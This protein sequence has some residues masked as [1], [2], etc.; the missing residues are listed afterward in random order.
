M[1][2]VSRSYRSVRHLGLVLAACTFPLMGC[3]STPR[4]EAPPDAAAALAPDVDPVRA[5]LP[6]SQVPPTLDAPR[7]PADL[8]ALSARAEEQIGK[9][10]PLMEELRYT[11]AALELERALRYD[12]THPEIHRTLALLHWQ[13]G[14]IERARS[15]AQR[16]VDINS[17]AA[18]AHYILG[19]YAALQE[20]MP[21]ALTE[22]RLALMCSDV[23]AQ[24][25]IEVLCHYHLAGALSAEGYLEA[26]LGEY[27]AF[28]QRAAALPEGPLRAELATLLRTT[29]G[30][31]G[32]SK[33]RLLERL[34]RFAE[35]ADAYRPI[36]AASPGEIER[37]TRFA[38][39]LTQAAKY[40]AALDVARAIESDDE[41]AVIKLMFEVYERAG[42][43][44]R[45]VDDLRA[46]LASRPDD[47]RLLLAVTDMLRGIGEHSAVEGLLGPYLQA[48]PES[49]IAR[50]RQLDTLS[51]ARD[52]D[53]L[54][55]A[56]ASAIRQEPARSAA[57][58]R[59][60]VIAAED[61]GASDRLLREGA[62]GS[63]PDFAT[64]YLLA[65]LANARRDPAKAKEYLQRSLAES[66]AFAPARVLLGR[67]HMQSYDYAAAL[68]VAGRTDR[69]VPEHSELERLLG[70][71][72]ERLDDVDQAELHYKAAIQLERTATDAM[73]ALAELYARSGRALQA[74]RQ[75]RVL[76]GNVPEHELAREMLAYS[77]L[78]EG[79]LDVAVQQ[80]TELRDRARRP[81]TVARCEALLEQLPARDIQAYRE[82]LREAMDKS[83]PD[84]RTWLAIAE[85]YSG[86]EEAAQAHEAYARALEVDPSDESAAVS[87]VVTSQQQLDFEQAARRLEALLPRRPNRHAWRRQLIELYWVLQDYDAALALARRE[88]QRPDLDEETRKSYR[89]RIADT[90]RFAGQPD[91]AIAQLQAWAA[92]E[93]DDGDWT[94]RL[95]EMYLLA[96]QPEKAVPIFETAYLQNPEEKG[97]LQRLIETLVSAKQ[98]DRASQFVLEWLADDPES[99]RAVALL[100]TVL[101]EAERAADALEL[102][103]DRL[104]HTYNRQFFQNMVIQTLR[105]AE[106]HEEGIK[107]IEDLLD[108][109][110]LLLQEGQAAPPGGEDAVPSLERLMRMPD[111]PFSAD[112]LH[113]RLSV[114]RL[115]LAWQHVQAKAYRTAEQLLSSWLETT[116]STPQRFQYLQLLVSC[117]QAQGKEST[118]LQTLESALVLRPDH[119]GFNNDLAY[120]LIEQ[121]TRLDEAERR[122]R[123]ALQ[124]APRTGAYLDT[125]GWLLYKKGDFARAKLWL[126]RANRAQGDADPVLLDHLGDTCWRLG[127]VE[128]AIVHWSAAVEALAKVNEERFAASDMRRVRE[129][130][131]IK[132]E[133]ARTGGRPE[134]APVAA[135]P[136]ESPSGDG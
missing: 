57:V 134:T 101:S 99:D 96:D 34:G 2:R 68:A 75:L 16:A 33:A 136:V 131:A 92:K 45:I 61:A 112:R 73:L 86:V 64:A 22:F 23:P 110:V 15:H 129:G 133:T 60:W 17:D 125:Y 10:Q 126:E 40:D 121:G 113:E 39:L 80:L 48:H 70:D 24:A 82:R 20:D 62:A 89:L 81:T 115:N 90:L 59:R 11:E 123:F 44:P 41:D 7:A 106:R 78:K 14:N 21:A 100:A 27:A 29:R 119:V 118:A 55:R 54:L 132:I 114:L 127:L 12:P 105:S 1:S 109:V 76:L 65:A 46:R 98:F 30:S 79:K 13:A 124:Q 104:L 107:W 88:E 103:R 72:H 111:E 43:P 58:V 108:E 85:S 56:S 130:T 84:V 42:K 67:L 63:P 3:A 74:Q 116:Q 83:E 18:V 52:W 47:L 97:H 35:A 37:A 5:R 94:M 69:D 122:I 32:E 93:G 38:R 50:E 91:E 51:E 4:R 19:R 77:Y 25:Q 95:A 31:A 28:E 66:G 36:Y 53:A 87:L 102:L 117:Y 120:M 6:L 26:A 8:P 9:A 135:P 128:E 49:W 71:L